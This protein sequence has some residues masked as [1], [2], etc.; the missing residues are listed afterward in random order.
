[1]A[2]K[3]SDDELDSVLSKIEKFNTDGIRFV[4]LKIV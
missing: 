3:F 4:H 1:M 2:K